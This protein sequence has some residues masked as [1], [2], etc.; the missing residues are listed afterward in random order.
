MKKMLTASALLL[1]LGAGVAQAGASK[2]IMSYYSDWDVYSDNAQTRSVPQPAYA[3]PGSTTNGG[4]QATND[5]M[6][7]KL[8]YVNALTYDFLEVQPSGAIYFYDPYAD[9]RLPDDFCTQGEGLKQ[10]ICGFRQAP[11]KWGLGNFEAFAKLQNKSG[12]LRKFISIGGFG[13]DQSFEYAMNNP[14]V[15]AE[16]VRAV[17]D[18][19]NLQ[20]VDLD[21]EKQMSSGFSTGD[22]NRYVYLIQVLRNYLGP[23]YMITM[24]IPA[25]P[26][27]AKTVE[28]AKPGNWKTIAKNVN[29]IDL[30]TYDF[31]GAFDFPGVT[32]YL[33][34]VY[35]DSASPTNRFSIDSSVK[36]LL[37]SG[38]PNAQIVLGIPAYGRGLQNVP[39]QNNG[40]FQTFSKPV[41]KGELDDSRCVDTLPQPQSNACSGTFGYHYIVNQM[42]AG[43][44][45]LKSYTS[46]AQGKVNGAWAYLPGNWNVVYPD[47]KPD[48][49]QQTLN[50]LFISYANT[51]LVASIAQYAKQNE[52]GGMMMWE[53]R[54]DVNPAKQ[55]KLSLLKTAN[56]NL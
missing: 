7:A 18:A 26:A 2:F 6:L 29:Y 22:A 50:S 36:T 27:W 23:K 55:P 11:A 42:E 37:S 43:Q 35:A 46:S 44:N 54:G 41:P 28:Q 3:V 8:D 32:N 34:N 25:D 33:T 20:G 47:K 10:N 1:C 16:S 9:L 14:K 51:D 31:H 4:Q 48:G 15:F 49:G 12:T 17:L 24:A 21:Y 40:L 30:M 19:Y 38:V 52:L 5:D 53:L 13:H 45:G 39:N 56:D